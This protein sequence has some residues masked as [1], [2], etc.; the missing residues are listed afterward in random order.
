MFI[1]VGQIE[2]FIPESGSLKSKRFVLKSIKTK[3]RNKFN[4]SIAEV[5]NNEKWQR[6]TLGIS[7]V[8]NDQKMASSVLNK[9]VNFIENDYRVEVVDF[10]IEI[11]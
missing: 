8:S 5:A 6:T 10:N 1:G 4:A 3:V 2:L 11:F 7:T 9:I